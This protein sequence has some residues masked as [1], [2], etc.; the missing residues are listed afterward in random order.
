MGEIP[1][2][3]YKSYLDFNGGTIFIVGILFAKTGWLFLNTIFNIWLTFWTENSL[4]KDDQFYINWYLSIGVAYGIFAFFRAFIFSFSNVRMS[5]HM[6]K[7]MISNLLFSSLNEFFDRVP[8]G[9]ILNRLSKD[10]NVV[11]ANFPSVTGNVLVFLFF[12]IGNTIIIVYCS[13]VWVLFPILIYVVCCYYLKNYY[14]KP[15]RELVRLESNTKSPI[16]SCFTEI[17]NGV[18]TIRAYGVENSFFMKNCQKIN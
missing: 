14:M 18:A 6:H 3:L 17:L 2:S 5:K 11:D 16:I 4:D 10:L 7:E 15:Q 1:W 9:R 13:T 12:L 8:L